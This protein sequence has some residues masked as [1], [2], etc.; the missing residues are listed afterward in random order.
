M[1]TSQLRRLF[2]WPRNLSVVSLQVEAV[3]ED[4]TAGDGPFANICQ[5]AQG[6]AMQDA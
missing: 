6:R 5:I 3:W 2:W 1:E 4:C